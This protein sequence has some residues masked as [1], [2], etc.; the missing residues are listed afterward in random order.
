M[1]LAEFINGHKT[2]AKA[3]RELGVSRQTIDRWQSGAFKPSRAMVRVAKAQGI[4]L[5]TNLVIPTS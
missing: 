1:T 2:V 4:D 5:T 3:A